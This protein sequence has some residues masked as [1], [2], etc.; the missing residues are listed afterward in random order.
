ML[1]IWNKIENAEENQGQVAS[2]EWVNVLGQR[3]L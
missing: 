2:M 1:D 3:P